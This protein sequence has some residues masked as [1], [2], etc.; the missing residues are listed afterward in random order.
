MALEFR[1]D[2]ILSAFQISP[3]T[4]QSDNT[5][6]LKLHSWEFRV[7]VAYQKVR[8]PAISTS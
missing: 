5:L 8:F 3:S 6:L 7:I 2:E 4:T 1:E